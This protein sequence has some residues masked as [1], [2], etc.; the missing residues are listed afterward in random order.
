MLRLNMDQLRRQRASET[1][2]RKR[3]VV[4]KLVILGVLFASVSA[5][6]LAAQKSSCQRNLMQIWFSA[7]CSV[8]ESGFEGPQRLAIHAYTID[9]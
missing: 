6:A 5:P 7:P 1:P 3:N 4:K 2:S 9:P 8:V